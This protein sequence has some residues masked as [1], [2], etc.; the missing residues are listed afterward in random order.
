LKRVLAVVLFAAIALASIGPIRNYDLFWHL[1]TGRWIA[2]HRALP[3]TDPFTVASDRTPWINGEWLFELVLHGFERLGGI[4][5]LSVVRSLFIAALFAFLFWFSDSLLLTALAFAGA[6]ATLDLRPASI[7]AFFVAISIVISRSNKTV[8]YILLTIL[9]INVHP[10]AL[11]A[12]A[13][14][15]LLTRKW[16]IT[17]AS[18]LALLVNQ[19]G[20]AHV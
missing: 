16:P 1:A 14:A 17:V 6:M 2:E 13:I 7:A 4:T 3:A 20:R 15:L 8:L 10:S 11:L 5:G 18:T 9:W 12:P 19:I